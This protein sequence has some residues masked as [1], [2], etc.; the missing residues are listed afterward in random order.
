MVCPACKEEKNKNFKVKLGV[1]E[2]IQ[3]ISTHEK[4]KHPDHRPNYIDA[5]PLVDIIRSVKGIKSST[6]KTVLNAYNKI[7]QE[8]GKEFEILIDTP[9]SKIEE[10]DPTI[11]SVIK[12]LRNNEI[13]Y[14]PGGGG[15]YGQINLE[16]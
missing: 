16:I 3:K 5:I 15:T 2:R 4:P 1:S 12:A 13:E 7:I 9:I 11:A 6:S 8:L 10:F 14:I